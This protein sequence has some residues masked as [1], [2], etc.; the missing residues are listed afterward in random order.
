MSCFF[1]VNIW[2]IPSYFLHFMSLNDE[3]KF[4]WLYAIFQPKFFKAGNT[5]IERSPIFS[6][7]LFNVPG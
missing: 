1:E 2:T 3:S 7:G 4:I 5:R 6:G